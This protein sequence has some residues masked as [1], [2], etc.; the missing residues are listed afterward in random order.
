MKISYMLL[1]QNGVDS[2]IPKG[3][4]WK[5]IL[6]IEDKIEIYLIVENLKKKI[7]DN[8]LTLVNLEID[9]LC[10]SDDF[11]NLACKSFKDPVLYDEFIP[12]AR[13][14]STHVENDSSK[15]RYD[16]AKTTL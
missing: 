14:I 4:A 15:F 10:S 6:Y 12:V 13:T 2:E 5:W 1:N 7:A 11:L 9:Q 16:Q 3:L 8:K